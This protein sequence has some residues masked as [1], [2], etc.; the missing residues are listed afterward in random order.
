MRASEFLREVDV[1]GQRF[2]GLQQTKHADGSKTTDYQQGPLQITNKVDAQGKPITSRG[3]YDL[4]LGIADTELDHAS[5]IRSNTFAP[6]VGDG[7][8]TAAT[9]AAAHRILPTAAS[10]SARG[11]DPKKFAA[12]QKQNPTAVKES[13]DDK[14]LKQMLSIAG[15]I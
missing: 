5:G 4:G 9:L 8:D 6:R 1:V 14:L 15:L 10:A 3:K 11:V 2:L 13:A 7:T 12:F